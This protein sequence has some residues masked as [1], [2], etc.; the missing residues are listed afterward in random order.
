[1]H[2]LGV[3]DEENIRD[4][5]K[6]I[7]RDAGYVRGAEI[8]IISVLAQKFRRNSCRQVCRLVP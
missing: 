4:L 2:I 6:D 3:D 5:L 1:M 7:L 8:K